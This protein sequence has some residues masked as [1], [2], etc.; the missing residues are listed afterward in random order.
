MRRL[1]AAAVCERARERESAL[2]RAR[3]SGTVV[4]GGE[5][6]IDALCDHSG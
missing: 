3:R 4:G 2:E 1:T 6:Y 5:N